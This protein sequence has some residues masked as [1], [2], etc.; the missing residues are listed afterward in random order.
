MSVYEED[1]GVRTV[2]LYILPHR[3]SQLFPQPSTTKTKPHHVSTKPLPLPS[4]KLPTQMA[5]NKSAFVDG[6]NSGLRI[7]D[8]PMPQPGPHDIIIRN[9]AI[10]INTIDPFQAVSGFKLPRYPIVLGSDV[11]G[12]VH[13]LGSAVTRF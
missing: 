9:A 5:T 11:A 10:A 4:N 1:H 3:T 8:S 13:S 2:Q 6:I 12:T 7:A